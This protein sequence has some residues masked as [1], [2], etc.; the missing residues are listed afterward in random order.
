MTTN[1]K[2]IMNILMDIAE[3]NFD[4]YSRDD[5]EEQAKKDAILPIV[6]RWAT[7]LADNI[8]EKFA[9]TEYFVSPSFNGHK[10]TGH[11]TAKTIDAD[12]DAINMLYYEWLDMLTYFSSKDMENNIFFLPEYAKDNM[13]I[14]AAC[15][16]EEKVM[17]VLRGGHYI[18]FLC[19]YNDEHL[20]I[21]ESELTYGNPAIMS[22]AD[23]EKVCDIVND[24]NGYWS[25][26]KYSD[27]K[28]S[29]PAAAIINVINAIHAEW[30]EA[31]AAVEV[32]A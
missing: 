26:I 2:E 28:D 16:S 31:I 19:D 23:W 6:E 15:D 20:L 22:E 4:C 3:D 27:E 1:K 32:T 12:D 8:G 30:L 10:T 25:Q 14:I 24:Y 13:S 11:F 5:K 17:A 21:A 18:S 7:Y 9:A 29:F